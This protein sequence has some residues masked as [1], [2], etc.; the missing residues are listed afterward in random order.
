MGITNHNAIIAT[1]W[2]KE[3]FERIEEWILR[4]PEI[5]DITEPDG[6]VRTRRPFVF[7]PTGM[8]NGFRTIVMV[9]DGSNEGCL[10]SGHF[11]DIRDRFIAEM[12]KANYPDG[13]SAWKYVEVSFGELGQS[14]VRGNNKDMHE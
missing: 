4:L 10:E 5:E 11:N 12:E 9:P 14:I 7:G 2:K 1:T 3:E 6:S 8:T 13:S